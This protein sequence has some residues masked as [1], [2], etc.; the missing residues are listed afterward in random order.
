SELTEGIAA[1]EYYLGRVRSLRGHLDDEGVAAAAAA[2]VER[3]L[4][5]H[6]A[7]VD[8]SDNY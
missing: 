2:T 1:V 6:D 4:K 3:P 7:D 8:W 5:T